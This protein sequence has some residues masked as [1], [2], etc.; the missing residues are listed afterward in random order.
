ME[1][2]KIK[3]IGKFRIKIMPDEDPESPRDWD[4]LGTMV[5][6]HGRYNLGDSNHGYKDSDHSNWAELKKQI[7][8]DHD[9]LVILPLFL[10]DH[11]G[12]TMSTGPFSCGWDSGQVGWIFT[13][14]QKVRENFEV[15]RIN[16]KLKDKIKTYLE[17]E[18]E[19]YDQYL[20]GD[21]YGFEIYEVTT[22]NLGHEH[23]TDVDSCWGFYGEDTA[24]E[25][26]EAVV[27]GIIEHI[28]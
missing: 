5:C 25:E 24:M 20:R 14:K 19:T 8:K 9:V 18:V 10:Y 12:I 6:F 21:V 13:T 28:N 26:A 17:G 16:Q 3:D 22:C 15:K 23:E 4:N 27:Q 7:E 11:S 2:V 1:P